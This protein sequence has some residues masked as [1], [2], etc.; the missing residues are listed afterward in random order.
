MTLVRKQ[1]V[2]L[3]EDY[4]EELKCFER[5]REELSEW[6]RALR[7]YRVSGFSISKVGTIDS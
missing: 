1:E 2:L 7:I 5:D 3:G 4:S 6:S